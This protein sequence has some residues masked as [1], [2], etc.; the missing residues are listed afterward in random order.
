MRS[1]VSLSL[2]NAVGGVLVGGFVCFSILLTTAVF[3]TYS[4]GRGSCGFTR[5]LCP[6]KDNSIVCTS[7]AI[8]ALGFTAACD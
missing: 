1:V 3:A 8:S 6:G 2:L 5:V 7:R 4:G